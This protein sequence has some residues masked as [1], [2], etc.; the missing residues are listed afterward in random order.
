MNEVINKLGER[1][2]KS[3]Y[4]K[5]EELKSALKHQKEEGGMIGDILV[6]YGFIS[7]YDL[8][9]FIYTN[10]GTKFGEIL[11]EEKLIN[12]EQLNDVLEYQREFGGRIGD[13]CISKGYI[14][15]EQIEE[16][17]NKR[18]KDKKKLGQI[19]LE[20][21]I[22]SSKQLKNALDIQE[23]SGGILGEILIY[24]GYTDEKTLCR[25]LATQEEIGRIG[26]KIN[27]NNLKSLSYSIA[28]KY[29]AM[30]IHER[31][32]CYIVGVKSKLDKYQ[33][34][35]IKNYLGKEVKQVLV[36][37]EEM[38]SMWEMRFKNIQKQ[39]SIFDLYDIQPEN[40]AI[41]T[42]TTPQVIAILLIGIVILIGVINNWRITLFSINIIFQIVYAVMTISKLYIV[43]KGE[44]N[45]IQLRFSENDIKNIDE[46]ELPIYTILIP[47]YKETE[48]IKKLLKNI[49]EI[50]YPKYKLDVRILLEEDDEETIDIIR[51]MSLPS[52]YTVIIVPKSQPQTK[53]KAC[54]YGLIRAKGEYVVIYD[55]EDRPEPDQLKK[56]YL[57][58]KKLSKEYVC[59]QAKLN[60]FNSNQNVLTKLFTQEY[61]M[62][63]ELLLVGIMQMN[64]PIPLGGTSNH[65]KL[66]FLKEVGGW[67]PFNVTEDA[68]LGIRLFKFKYKTAILDSRTWEEANSNVLNWIR[69]RS[70][71]I[72]GYMQTWLVHMRHPIE[73]FRTIGLKGFMGY[74]AMILGTPLLPLINPIF[75]GL[76]VLWYATHAGWIKGL[77]PGVFYYIAAFQLL[78]GN[79]MFMYVNI[80]GMYHVIRDCALKGN[81]CFSYGL[82]KYALITPIYWILM[83][84][85]SY[86]ALFQLIKNPFY[87]EKT[88][89]GLV[90]ED[91]EFND[92]S[93]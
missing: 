75:W 15:N 87:W 25:E 31:K 40:S 55:A 35:D 79:F 59:I 62:W 70:R 72:K 48:V 42:F 7:S 28:S 74:Q 76:L 21:E 63:F 19:L 4:I 51:N 41:V 33:I 93:I 89:H 73:L 58:F 52:N 29:S 64:I 92:L 34:E 66:S 17:I 68:D 6:R 88:E 61:S 27:L 80:I 67:D 24:L 39:K 49:E 37:E 86:K 5:E 43:L 10:Q 84:I 47:V 22:I 53:P 16:I 8:S 20:K 23:K 26:N 56:T 77:F 9:N 13:I 14:K 30:V 46:K 11:I 32:D 71:W 60:Y 65:F 85:A 69:Q 3:G 91:M 38:N 12:G 1:L 44:R 82:I 54:N 18:K 45:N 90:E 2:L 83:S 36:T 78:F 50:D 57:A 81:Q